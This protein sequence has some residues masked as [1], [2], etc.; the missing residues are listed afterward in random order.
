[1]AKKARIEDIDSD[2]V[3]NS[4]RMGDTSIPPQARSTDGNMTEILPEKE[5][6]AAISLSAWLINNQ[7]TTRTS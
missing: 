4:F 7:S 5:T 3:I 6:Q 1:M 2:A